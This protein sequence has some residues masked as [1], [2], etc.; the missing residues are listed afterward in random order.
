MIGAYQQPEKKT[1]QAVDTLNEFLRKMR[2]GDH[3]DE[4]KEEAPEP[5]GEF[6]ETYVIP[7]Q[8]NPNASPILIPRYD[9]LE[10]EGDSEPNETVPDREEVEK[11]ESAEHITSRKK[12]REAE[13][14]PDWHP[15]YNPHYD[16]TI[17][18]DKGAKVILPC[19]R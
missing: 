1:E 5:E 12:R 9:D 19:G 8:F 16:P 17:K 4:K 14:D 7:P 2:N 18:K 10:D 6:W 15:L 3:L 13:R 11:K